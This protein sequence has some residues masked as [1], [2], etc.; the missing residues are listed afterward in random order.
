MGRKLS[1]DQVALYRGC[2]EVLHFIWDPIGVAGEPYA[3]DEYESYLPGIFRMLVEGAAR[4]ELIHALLEIEA[5]S[6][7]LHE[8]RRRAEVAV[9]ALLRWRG[10]WLEQRDIGG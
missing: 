4:E 8:G 9:D 7:G 10:W 5:G 2:D 6:M 3:R 1:P